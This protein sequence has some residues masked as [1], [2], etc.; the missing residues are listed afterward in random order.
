[1]VGKNRLR[2]VLGAGLGEGEPVAPVAAAKPTLRARLHALAF[3][4][5]ILALTFGT[6]VV[7]TERLTRALLG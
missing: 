5:A 3:R 7:V 2:V 6:S 1:M 4:G